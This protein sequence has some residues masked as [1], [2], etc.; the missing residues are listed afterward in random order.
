ML[1]A[2]MAY[3]VLFGVLVS[4]AALAVERVAATWGRAQRFV[5]VGALVAAVAAPSTFASRPRTLALG[6]AREPAGIST[7]VDADVAVPFDARMPTRESLASRVS[8]IIAASDDLMLRV[9]VLASLAGVALIVR[10]TIGLRRRRVRWRRVDVDG[11]SVLVSPNVGPAVVGALAPR[12]VIPQW[13]LSLAP[14][15]RAL[16]LRHEVEHIRARDPLLLFAAVT[17]TALAPW[18]AALWFIV[19]RLR[20]A[21]EIDCDQR[22]L[23]SSPERREYGEL[24]LTV[25]ARLNAPLPFATSL[26]ERRPSIERRIRA[27]TSIRPR[28]PRIVSAA[29]VVLAAATTAAARSPRPASLV[30]QSALASTTAPTVNA[31]VPTIAPTIVKTATT[32]TVPKVATPAPTLAA[33]RRA[34]AAPR[35]GP[36]S[37]TVQEIRAMIAAHHPT[38]LVGDPDINTITLVVNARGDYVVSL[39]ESRPVDD[40]VLGVAFKRAA[41]SSD[42]SAYVLRSAAERK[43]L[44]AKVADLSELRQQ[45]ELQRAGAAKVVSDSVVETE[46]A[47]TKLAAALALQARDSARV[48]AGTP[49][50]GERIGLNTPAL[51]QLIDPE[52][53]STVR[54]HVF[55]PGELGTTELRVFVVRQKY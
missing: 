50:L 1:L 23:R 34:P 8:R 49:T 52:T 42:D 12:V 3:S 29:C 22:V 4:A 16:M 14:S 24:L 54:L 55:Q 28:H 32:P 43:M 20:L 5:W 7:V 46:A 27:M 13:S 33:A 26:A 40:V 6:A 21:V 47:K 18:N 41:T 2:W 31:P 19:R 30:T 48:L 10:A 11:V 53:I 39:A 44:M 45:I 15:A 35:R 51:A 17:T 9:W 38:A 37:L 36:D 25:G